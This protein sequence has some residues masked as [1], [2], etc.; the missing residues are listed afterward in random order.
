MK[1][2]KFSLAAIMAMGVSSFASENLADAFKDGSFSGEVKSFYFDRSFDSNSTRTDSDIL[3]FGIKMDYETA[4]FYGFRL[5]A[6][7]Q[8]SSSPYADDDA[9]QEYSG[10]YD[11]YGPGTVLSQAY[12][13]YAFGKTDLKIGRQYLNIPLMR[14]D[15]SRIVLQAFEGAS[16]INKDLPNTTLMGAYVTK[17]Q[18]MT[19]GDG[20]IPD[21][22]KIAN[23]G[24]YAYVI[25]AENKS[26]EDLKLT[27]AYGEQDESHSMSQIQ[28]DYT[29]KFGSLDYTFGAQHLTTDYDSNASDDSTIFGLK[30]G[31]GIG[32]F[33][34]YIAYEDI[35]DGNP[36]VGIL[37]TDDKPT[38]YTSAVI[39]AG[40]YVESDQYAID[41]NYMI[42]QAD[43]LVG[44]RYVNVDY[45]QTTEEVEYTGLYAAHEFKSGM[46][47][48]FSTV[49]L[50]EDVDSNIDSNDLDEI[51][52]RLIYKF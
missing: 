50:Y 41:A 18:N 48:G 31:I 27:L 16:V 33:S 17:F 44:A 52:L 29:P 5:G 11:M 24:D 32:N 2:I 1:L 13:A 36:M 47:K 7:F 35:Q 28:A 20:D 3:N 43:L 4:D 34:T 22:E 26:I 12:L 10:P 9:K 23:D 30:A 25:A 37:G 49:L 6:G 40:V 19:S 46:L 15:G 38:L 21:F 45:A 39:E 14:S 42:E 51:R 8:S